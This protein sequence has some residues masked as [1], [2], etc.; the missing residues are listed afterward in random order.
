MPTKKNTLTESFDRDIDARREKLNRDEEIRKARVTFYK[1]LMAAQ[2]A[3]DSIKKDARNEFHKY[4]Y[5]SAQNIISTC[6]KALH[7]QGLLIVTDMVDCNNAILETTR[8]D[9]K[10]GEMVTTQNTLTTLKIKFKLIDCDS[11]ECYEFHAYG[12]GYDPTDKSVYKAI[13]GTEKYALLQ[14]L[15][16]P[17]GDDPE[18]DKGGKTGGGSKKSTRGAL[19]KGK[20][21]KSNYG[22]PDDKSNCKFCG[23]KHIVKGD[24]MIW[25]GDVAGA[26]KCADAYIARGKAS[27]SSDQPEDGGN[28]KGNSDLIGRITKG[29]E[30]LK[31]F[32]PDTD[33][34]D[35][36]MSNLDVMDLRKV[37]EPTLKGYMNF[38]GAEINAE[39]KERGEEEYPF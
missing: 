22:K 15:Q 31:D 10:T 11:G 18:N 14:L 28:G 3:V 20:E 1:K 35:L 32:R 19:E 21:F 9:K 29:E 13:T 27:G 30:M 26:K 39:K 36:R 6:R 38:L 23:E 8:L 34:K 4:D 25:V 24:P 7:D 37:D 17:T 16:V 5:A 2:Q 33:I 12:T